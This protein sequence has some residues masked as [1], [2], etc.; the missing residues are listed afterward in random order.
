MGLSVPSF[1]L[2]QEADAKRAA[3]AQVAE[4]QAKSAPYCVQLGIRATSLTTGFKLT[5]GASVSCIAVGRFT[6]TA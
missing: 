4:L 2:K 5:T 6:Y 3:L 1:R